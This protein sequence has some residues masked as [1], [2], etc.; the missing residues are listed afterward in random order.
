[1]SAWTSDEA[2][3]FEA[4]ERPL[5]AESQGQAP[6][7]GRLSG[8]KILVVGGGQDDRGQSDPPIGNGRA[9]CVLFSREGAKVVC[10]DID[11][12]SAVATRD[13]IVEAGGTAWSYA[14]DVADR[15]ARAASPT[16]TASQVLLISP[17]PSPPPAG[18]DEVRSP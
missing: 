7:R 4:A 14:L 5:S 16:T 6:G 18:T 15:A 2:E 17:F 12:A 13:A 3:A 8:R 1:M 9:M 10:L 11:A